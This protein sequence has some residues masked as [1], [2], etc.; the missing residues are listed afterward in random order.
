MKSRFRSVI[1][2]TFFCLAIRVSAAPA[3]QWEHVYPHP[4]AK[5]LSA[6]A[7]G[8]AG[9][10]AAGQ[11]GEILFS[12]DASNWRRITAPGINSTWFQSA[13]YSE[14]KYIVVGGGNLILLSTNGQDWIVVNSGTNGL[15]KGC[16]AGAGAFAA[17]GF[18]QTLF[19]ST[20]GTEWLERRT[21]ADFVDIAF[22]NGI[23]IALTG[24]ST[25][26]ASSNLVDWARMETG[27]FGQPALTSICFGNGQFVAGG[28][29]R[30]DEPNGVSYGTAIK[31]STDGLNWISVNGLDSFGEIRSLAFGGGQFVA[32]L[33]GHFLRS[34][35]GTTWE[36]VSAPNVA[37]DFA[38]VAASDS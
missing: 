18:N 9:F 10:V 28:A 11:G 36:H 37:G 16:A 20:N 2:V 24:G 5:W 31:T 22:G 21:L 25:I 17:V 34:G 6:I 14:G 15:L 13:C 33:S 35:D 19:V 4:T 38:G 7:W 26:Y 1:L 3:V 30:P 29:G 8:P 27:Y 32:A 12:A 23:W